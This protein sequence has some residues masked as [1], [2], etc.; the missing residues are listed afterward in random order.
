MLEP[1]LYVVATPIGNLSDITYRA[2]DV[3][4]QAN[5]IAA[6]DTRHSKILLDHYNIAT[7]LFSVHDFNEQAKQEHVK[8]LIEEGNSVALISD[9]GTPL[10]SDPGYH[11]VAY[12][13][14]SGVKVYPV[15]GPC[16]CISALCASGL[17]TDRFIFCGFLPVKDKALKDEL[18]RHVLE[19]ATV[20]YY[21]SPRRVV[22]TLEAVCSVLGGDRRIVIARELTKKFEQ[23]LD[24]TAAEMLNFFKDSPASLK[25][26]F[27]L[28]IAGVKKVA[29]D[30]SPEAGK[31]MRLLSAKMSLKD[32]AAVCAEIFGAKK[33][34]LYQFGLEHIEQV[35]DGRSADD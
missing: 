13:R 3:L 35:K 12:L 14:A 20:V 8:S 1:G 7:K 32:A 17:P 11:L 26:E 25:G 21:E 30:V 18:A 31:A 23:F 29:A 5:Y 4:S 6:E 19:E 28:L 22:D 34:A 2:V 16:A 9:A 15:P 27:V 24:A 10:I 33:N